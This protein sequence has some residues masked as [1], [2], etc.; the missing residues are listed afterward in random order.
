MTVRRKVLLI[1]ILTAGVLTGALYIVTRL[2]VVRNLAQLEK[3]EANDAI[4]RVEIAIN[5][6]LK[7]ISRLAGDWATREETIAF[8]ETGDTKHIEDNFGHNL[9]RGM[10]LDAAIFINAAGKI[11][12]NTGYDLRRGTPRIITKELAPY[13]TPDSPLLQ[14]KNSRDIHSGILVLQGT[15]NMLVV[16]Y[17]IITTTAKGPIRGSVVFGRTFDAGYYTKVTQLAI[18]LAALGNDGGVIAN[19]DVIEGF[20]E[21][22][23]APKGTSAKYYRA[24]TPERMEVYQELADIFDKPNMIIQVTMPRKT[25]KQGMGM[26]RYLLI[27]LLSISFAAALTS[28]I[29]LDRTVLARLARLNIAVRLIASRREMSARVQLM[30]RDELASLARS[31]NE[32]LSELEVAQATIQH[33]ANH[34]ALTDL[35]NRSLFYDRLA[36][37]LLNAWRNGSMLAVLVLDIDY[38]K[39]VNDTFGHQ[40]GDELLQSLAA[41]LRQTLRES[42]IISRF[43]GDEFVLLLSSVKEPADAGVVAEK[44]LAALREPF[45]LGE[46]SLDISASIGIS[47]F[48][49]DFQDAQSLINAADVALYQAKNDGRDSYCFYTPS[50]EKHTLEQFARQQMYGSRGKT[51]DMPQVPS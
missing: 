7:N 26:L 27:A 10:Q 34:D 18:I 51:K 46:H 2:I 1:M 50:L 19:P 43:G 32:M 25:Y 45:H 49:K 6:D 24:I 35:P 3:K 23:K 48:P 21:Y 44:L 36:Q 4:S 39:L 29:V 28:S 16:S 9:G 14:H 12:N 33:Q 5:G 30:G 13:L 47:F 15:S 42:D 37:G 22:Q 41:R 20:K 38:F 8:V 40:G 31:I 17:P 11:V